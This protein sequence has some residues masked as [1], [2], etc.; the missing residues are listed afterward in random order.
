M[1]FIIFTLNFQKVTLL[2]FSKRVSLAYIRQPDVLHVNKREYVPVNEILD[3]NEGMYR[4]Y[5]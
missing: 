1:S 4:V 5:I 3:H 2:L